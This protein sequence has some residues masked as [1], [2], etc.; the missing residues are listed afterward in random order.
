[1]ANEDH[2]QTDIDFETLFNTVVSN[3]DGIKSVFSGGI[4]NENN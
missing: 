3:P 1:M 2:D 4:N